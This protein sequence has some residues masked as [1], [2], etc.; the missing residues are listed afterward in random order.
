MQVIAL[1]LSPT[2]ELSLQI[3]KVAE[4][5]MASVPGCRLCSLIGGTDVAGDMQQVST[6]AACIV[7]TP[8]RVHDVLTR[9]DDLSFK[10]FEM[11]VLDEADR[12]LDMGFQEQLDRI[13]DRLPKQRRT[14]LFSATQTVCTI[15]PS[16]Q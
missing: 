13:M 5:F 2:R 3:H 6:G 15:A 11:L 16:S 14:G 8:G 9:K 1:I 7:G 12:L 10:R 4:P